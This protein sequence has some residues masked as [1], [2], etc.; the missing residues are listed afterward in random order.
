LVDFPNAKDC[1]PQSSIGGGV[2]YFLWDRDNKSICN[3]TNV[4]GKGFITMQ[5]NLNEFDVFVR[6]NQ[7]IAIIRKTSNSKSC[8]SIYFFN[9][10][11]VSSFA[12][13]SVLEQ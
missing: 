12:S 10:S 7:A 1:F 9:I 4:T 2:C 13:P 6:Y 3:V 8:P 5:R 11:F